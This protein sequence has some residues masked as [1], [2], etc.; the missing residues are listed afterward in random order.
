MSETK[1]GD[2][3]VEEV[4]WPHLVHATSETIMGSFEEQAG[5]PVTL[6]RDTL[7]MNCH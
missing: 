6:D 4:L 2:Q 5:T 1:G 3:N 7:E